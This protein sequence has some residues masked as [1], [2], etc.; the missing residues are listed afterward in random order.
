D[1]LNALTP[2][3]VSVDIRFRRGSGDIHVSLSGLQQAQHPLLAASGAR[4]LRRLAQG[5]TDAEE[6]ERNLSG[7]ELVQLRQAPPLTLGID[8]RQEWT[9]VV[10]EWRF[11]VQLRE[12]LPMLA[13]PARALDRHVANAPLQVG[14]GRNGEPLQPSSRFHLVPVA[15][16]VLRIL[17]VIVEEE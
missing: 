7:E 14:P 13:L 5:G 9:V 12:R 6:V 10:E 17:D 2:E 11:A 4:E 1:H 8:F 16:V 15:P 3:P